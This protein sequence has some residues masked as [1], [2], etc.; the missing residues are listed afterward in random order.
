VTL[1]SAEVTRV[2][3]WLSNSSS[4]LES[5]AY[6]NINTNFPVGSSRDKLVNSIVG[7]CAAFGPPPSTYGAAWPEYCEAIIT[8]EI[9][10]E[11]SYNPTEVVSD[12]YATQNGSN[13]PTVGLL[14]IRYSSTVHD[15]NYNGPIATIS[16][17]GC[18]WPTGL[19]SQADVTTYWRTAGGSSTNIAFMED[20]A[21]NIP[22]AAWYVFLDA[23]GN[24]GSSAV[25]AAQYCAGQGVAG[26]VVDGLLSHL[27]GPGYPRPADPN[28]A[29]PAGIKTRFV[30]LVG[31]TLP[32]PDPFGVTLSPAPAQYC[33]CM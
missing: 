24:G 15:F 32:S 21:C 23:T 10:S 31:G 27:D 33:K 20:P 19:T 26:N 17:I 7:A 16:S 5:Y 8:S 3:G 9:V 28:N 2:A 25:Y 13:D 18:T 4:G 6:T 30:K 14:Q 11:S 12:A 1:N 29:Y 22:L